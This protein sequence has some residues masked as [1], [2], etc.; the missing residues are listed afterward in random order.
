MKTHKV[1][2]SAEIKSRIEP[3]DT[4]LYYCDPDIDFV[5]TT[6]TKSMIS[7]SHRHRENT[8]SYYVFKGELILHIEGTIEVLGAGDMTV[9][10]PGTCHKFETKD[11]AVTFCA[12]K[13]S[14][15]LAD[16]ESCQQ[17]AN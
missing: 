14:P 12:I 3:G 5:F 6:I 2:R 16:K 13:K 10:Y 7:E 1:M 8:E 11:G 15:L 9:I 4:R 17:E